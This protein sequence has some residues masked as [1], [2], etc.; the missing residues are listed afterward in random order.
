[1]KILLATDGFEEA[2]LAARAAVELA[3]STG[4]ELHVVHIKLLPVSS[5]SAAT[6]ASLGKALP[7][8]TDA[9]AEAARSG[10]VLLAGP[11]SRM[12]PARPG[13]RACSWL[14]PIRG[15]WRPRS[16]GKEGGSCVGGR[17]VL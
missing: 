13:R 1:M 11:A 17:C 10:H 15:G 3:T 14:G 12:R 6:A 4:S 5:A 8:R 2:A 16:T 9:R 7:S